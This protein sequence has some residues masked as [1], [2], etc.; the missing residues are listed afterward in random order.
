MMRVALIDDSDEFLGLLENVIRSFFISR[1]I[2]CK[3]VCYQNPNLFYYDIMES[4]SFD[5][6]F[7][8]IEMPQMNG[9]DLARKLRQANRKLPLIFLTAHSEYMRAG[10]EVKAFDY[11]SK[12]IAKDEVIGVLERLMGEIKED[13][14]HIYVIDSNNRMERLPHE[15]IIYIY[16]TGQYSRFVMK[17]GETQERKALKDI[18]EKLDKELFLFVE[19][20]FIINLEHVSRILSRNVVLSNGAEVRA[21]KDHIHELKARLQEF[22]AQG[23]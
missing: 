2:A 12:D 8:D 9:I 13:R 19:R 5:V 6:C 4:D 10:Y 7:L 17:H 1:R 18:Y 14:K 22:W 20:G 11:L 15:E 3:I 23:R 21:S 16:K